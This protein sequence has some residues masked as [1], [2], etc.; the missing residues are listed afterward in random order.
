MTIYG[1]G[2]KSINY[3]SGMSL[4]SKIYNIMNSYNSKTANHNIITKKNSVK[5]NWQLST[6]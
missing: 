1:M 4:V 5:L 2:E 6:K 3:I